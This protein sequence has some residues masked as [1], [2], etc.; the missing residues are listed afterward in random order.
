MVYVERDIREIEGIYRQRDYEPEETSQDKHH[1]VQE[2][3]KKEHVH[4]QSG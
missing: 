3:R 4:V 1:K 2:H